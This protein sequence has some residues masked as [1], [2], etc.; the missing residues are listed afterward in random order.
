MS[1]PNGVN[2]AARVIRYT[3][4]FTPATRQVRMEGP[5]ETQPQKILAMDTLAQAVSMLA[6]ALAKQQAE[7]ESRIV[8]PRLI[9]D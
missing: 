6:G 3:I 1:T 2:P 8:R 9:G 5:L 7:P 4:E